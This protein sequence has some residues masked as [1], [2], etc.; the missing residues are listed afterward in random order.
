MEKFTEKLGNALLPLAEKLSENR[1]L[2]SI[3]SGFSAC[4][5]VVIVGA[6]FTLLANLNITFYQNMITAAHLKDIFSFVPKITTD[7]LALYS[8]YSISRAAAGNIGMEKQADSIGLLTLAVFLVMIPLGVTG[9]EKDITVVVAAALSTTYLGAAG[10]FT[11]MI[12]GLVIPVLYKFFIDKN[13]II[14]MPDS[15]PPQI[16]TSFQGILPSFSILLL[17]ALL[18]FAFSLTA[19]GDIN[20]CIYTLLKAPLAALG[21]SPVTMIV[22]I[23]M[24]S[25]MWFFGL[26]GGMIVMPFINMLYMPLAMENLTAYGA[27]A[28]LPNIIVKS[29]WSGYASLGGAGG[30]VGLC[31]IMCFLAK[32]QRYKALGKLALPSGICGI[33]EPITFGLP[34][35]LNTIMLIP[36]IFTPIITFTL[37]YLMTSIGVIPVMNGMEIPLGTPI[38]LAGMLCGGWKLAVWQAVL[39]LVQI[40]C[41]FPFFKVLDTQALKEE[42]EQR[43]EI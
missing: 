24:C 43:G 19:Y 36:L 1:Y 2:K 40:V 11:A 20:T 22:M 32:S 33:N 34:M 39:V 23:L 17:A 10:L 16:A 38:L 21:A 25:I 15:V 8:V 4:L 31:V 37:S 13:L 14:R 12:F 41:Y 26:H 9:T 6:L 29:A 7:M 3:S 28:Q 5:P 35:V 18:R 42:Q 27:G 30:T